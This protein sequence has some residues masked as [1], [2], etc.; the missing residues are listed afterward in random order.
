MN[1][2]IIDRLVV[3]PETPGELTAF[4]QWHRCICWLLLCSDDD[5]ADLFQTHCVLWHMQFTW[6]IDD[7]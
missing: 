4:G 7:I 3:Q 2:Q 6:D 1:K 5:D